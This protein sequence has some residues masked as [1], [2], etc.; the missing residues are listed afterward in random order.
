MFVFNCEETILQMRRFPRAGLVV[1]II[2]R[3]L[4]SFELSSQNLT[5]IQGKVTDNRSGED[6]AAATIRLGNLNVGTRTD[7][8]GRFL[9]K[10]M[11]IAPSVVITCLGYD[12]LVV[13]IKAGEINNIEAKLVESSRALQ[14]VEVV[15]KSKKY[16][17]KDNP[18]VDFMREVIARKEEN[19]KE[20]LDYY[21]LERYDKIEFALNNIDDKFR[22]N[23][24][25]RKTQFIFDNLDTNTVTGKVN[26]P[27]YLR[28]TLSDVYYRKSPSTY[29][30]YIRGEKGTQLP[31]YVDDE[32]MA[33]MIENLYREIDFYK[34]AINL[35]TVDF[36]S[37]LADLAPNLYEF[38]LRDTSFLGN[39]R[40][41]H[42]YFTPRQKSDLAFNGDMW[43]AFD[44]TYALRKIQVE[45]P[46]GVNLN[47]V[48][49]LQVQQSFDW[50]DMPGGSALLPVSDVV[51]MEFG[52]IRSDNFQSVLAQKTSSYAKYSINQPV[53]E[54]LMNVG[55][56]IHRDSSAIQRDETFWITHRHDTLDRH[57]VGVYK[58]LD[59]LQGNVG[60][61]NFMDG[62]KIVMDGY[63]SHGK[64]E[65]GPVSS[66]LGF[67]PI[68]GIRLRFGGRTNLKF[69]KRFLLEGY[70]AYGIRDERLKGFAGLRYSFGP[71]QVNKYPLHQFRLWYLNDMQLPGQDVQNSLLLSLR[72]GNNDKMLYAQTIL[73][74]CLEE[75]KNG[76]SYSTSYRLASQEAAGTL[77]FDYLTP[78]GIAQ[79][80]TITINELELML[81]YAPNEKF[82]QS[83][84]TRL[85]AFNKYPTF[86]LWY[87]AGLK[88]VMGGE[89]SYHKVRAKIS[90]GIY[91]S[92]IGWANASVEAGR[93]FGQLPYTLLLVHPANQSFSYSSE[94]YNLMNNFEFVSDKYLALRITHNFGG[95]FFNRIPLVRYLKLREVLTCKVLW[96]GLDQRNLPTAENGLILLPVN[97][98]GETI[99]H[100]LEKKPYIEAS[101]G[102]SN[103]FR[104]LR[105]DLVHRVNYLNL[106]DTSPFA[107]RGKIQV[108]F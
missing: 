21:S 8:N 89:Y 14:E 66:F 52:L 26:L 106:P 29:R 20:R 39:V 108:E 56:K 30:E 37:P 82:Y 71:D 49:G 103:I 97:E 9:L 95:F 13:P 88:G 80:K 36:V 34:N 107:I 40:C 41:V 96:G 17:K 32:G 73:L 57:E 58:M 81:R 33:N 2:I 79:R 94:S 62:L 19:R 65:Y 15:S 54:A 91:I 70:G 22:K 28:E 3:C 25:F 76:F 6:I 85:Y 77:R 45:V 102:I 47:W 59:S 78:D 75:W 93:I 24:F 55:G 27:F 7:A 12:S 44:S 86:Q 92:P 105:V 68:E 43:I 46:A 99:T 16:K 5:V 72:R 90:K 31:G 83:N 101:F 42:V 10:S 61:K 64:I 50:V 60:F 48:N 4:I 38:Y 100:S 104:I 1:F 51:Q 63:Y 84:D 98:N 67:N 18:A 11:E 23:F 53:S 87:S 74:E 35:V 69:S